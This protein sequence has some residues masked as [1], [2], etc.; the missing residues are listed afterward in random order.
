MATQPARVRAIPEGYHTVTPH[1][2]VRGAGRAIEFYKKAFGAQ[3]RGRMPGPGGLL[4]HAELK[5]GDSVVMLCDEF[6]QMERWVA[7]DSLKGTTT[8]LHLYVEDADV[9]FAR[10]V[11][12]GA[13]VSM[14][15]MD[16]FWGDRY[17][18]LTDPF[19][20]EW[21]VATHMHD[22]TPEEVQKNAEAFFAQLPKPPE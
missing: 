4:M 12:A 10:A 1:L 16:A 5:I 15:L 9:V 8:A 19:G 22:Y 21:S 14:P 20:H 17:G 13:K 18:K 3:E 11:A 6:P 2:V 7:P